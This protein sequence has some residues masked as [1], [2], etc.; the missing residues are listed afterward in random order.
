MIS[1]L[2]LQIFQA[3]DEIDD[4]R[5]TD[6]VHTKVSVQPEHSP[7][8]WRRRIR[9]LRRVRLDWFNDSETDKP[10]EAVR[11]YADCQCE[12]FDRQKD[13]RHCPL[14]P[15]ACQASAS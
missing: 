11:A 2:C 13:F 4:D 14:T 10:H 1:Q 6:D 15:Q 9:E 3:L 7:Q 8:P 12:L 5:R